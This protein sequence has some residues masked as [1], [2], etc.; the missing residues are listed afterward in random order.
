MRLRLEA[1]P[2]ELADPRTVARLAAALQPQAP[3]LAK[4]LT[5]AADAVPLEMRDPALQ[6]YLD[7][8][9]SR[10]QRHLSRMLDE[11]GKELDAVASTANPESRS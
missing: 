9:R 7:R 4:A 5:A 2:E 10:Y 8:V 1:T 3:V 6:A 11:I